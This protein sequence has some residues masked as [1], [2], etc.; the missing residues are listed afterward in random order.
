MRYVIFLWR[1]FSFA[2]VGC[3]GLQRS[4]KR[5]IK[6]DSFLATQITWSW[7]GS[8]CACEIWFISSSTLL[9]SCRLLASLPWGGFV[10]QA[11][12]PCQF[13]DPTLLVLTQFTISL[14]LQIVK[15]LQ[16]E[17]GLRLPGSPLWVPIPPQDMV[18]TTLSALWCFKELK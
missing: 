14:M 15:V 12:H 3:W 13:W 9:F 1:T 7:A 5:L 16:D 8:L 17:S 11:P 6:A 4:A 10:Y 2:S 18:F